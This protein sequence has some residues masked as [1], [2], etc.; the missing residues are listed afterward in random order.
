MFTPSLSE[1]EPNSTYHRYHGAP[2]PTTTARRERQ[3][4]V[5]ASQAPQ[6]RRPDGP[7]APL[8]PRG[9][10][11]GSSSTLAPPFAHT[12]THQGLSWRMRAQNHA[13]YQRANHPASD[14]QV[15]RVQEWNNIHQ[16]RTQHDQPSTRSL[17]FHPQHIDSPEAEVRRKLQRIEIEELELRERIKGQQ[18]QLESTG[19]E[20]ERKLGEKAKFEEL[21][22]KMARRRIGIPEYQARRKAENYNEVVL[23]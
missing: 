7:L 4:E 2:R 21:A 6:E 9:R 13:P 22:R 10:A 18:E 3:P 12:D 1:V 23:D 11:P 16:W 17:T 19:R 14:D 5:T 20:L 8:V 15:K